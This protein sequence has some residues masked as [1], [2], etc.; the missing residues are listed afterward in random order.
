MKR[1][2]YKI[3]WKKGLMSK[4]AYGL[5]HGLWFQRNGEK[6]FVP[7]KQIKAYFD[8]NFG[9]VEIYFWSENPATMATYSIMSYRQRWATK[10]EDLKDI[11]EEKE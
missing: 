1:F 8:S 7:A 4:L 2:K 11:Y 10:K 5:K 6:F 3:D 9:F